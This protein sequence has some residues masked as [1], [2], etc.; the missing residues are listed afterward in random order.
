MQKIS[1]FL[2]I[3]A[4]AAGSVYNARTTVVNVVNVAED[5][6]CSDYKCLALY[7]IAAG[8]E[9]TAVGVTFLPKNNRTSAVF[10]GFACTSK[11]SLTVRNKYKKALG[12]LGCKN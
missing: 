2:D 9:L 10:A 1:Q 3:G 12:L 4:T 8:C 7:C 11:F 6:A 5:Y